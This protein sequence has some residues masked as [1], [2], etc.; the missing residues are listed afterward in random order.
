[1]ARPKTEASG[2]SKPKTEQPIPVYEV[3]V[4][5]TEEFITSTLAK[6]SPEEHIAGLQEQY[7]ALT[8]KGVEDKEGYKLATDAR[9]LVKNVRTKI[10]AK[11]KELKQPFWDMGQAIDAEAKRLTA[12]VQP[13]EKHLEEQIKAIDEE[14]LRLRRA[15]E[16]RRTNLL[17]EAGFQLAG[18]WWRAGNSVLLWT[19]VMEL[20]DEELTEKLNEGRS[21]V[22]RIAAEQEAQR[23]EAERIANERAE[24]AR[25][26]EE[27]KALKRQLAEKEAAIAAYDAAAAQSKEPAAT[28]PTPEQI[29]TA[30]EGEPPLWPEDEPAQVTV[31]AIQAPATQAATPSPQATDGRPSMAPYMRTGPIIT[32]EPYVHPSIAAANNV[33]STDYMNGY[34]AAKLA[35]IEILNRPDKFTRGE[36]KQMVT[37][38]KP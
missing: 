33:K 34:S 13:I 27:M 16:L 15:E 32:T 30:F 23:L 11:R 20:T 17:T 5:S 37:N 25:Q 26:M 3:E 36:L 14:A 28:A 24:L 1:M 2:A 38:L 7:G 9:K 10:E 12:M 6:L 31:P 21:E 18:E 4:I 29:A 8:I 35:V 22:A 19:K